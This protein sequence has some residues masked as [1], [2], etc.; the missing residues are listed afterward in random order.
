MLEFTS[1]EYAVGGRIQDQVG[2][3][4]GYVKEIYQRVEEELEDEPDFVLAIEG[5]DGQ[6]TLVRSQNAKRV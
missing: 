2:G 1:S 4:V 5:G 3:T 6:I